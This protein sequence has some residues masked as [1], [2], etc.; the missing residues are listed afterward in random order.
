[1]VLTYS[2]GIA[3]VCTNNSIG[4]TGQRPT[5][6]VTERSGWPTATVVSG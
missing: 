2:L 1:L 6:T 5:A 4:A 3:D